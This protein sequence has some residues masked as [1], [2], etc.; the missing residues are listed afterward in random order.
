MINGEDAAFPTDKDIRLSPR[1]AGLSKREYFAV[2][3]L[4]G[5]AAAG[6]ES[7]SVREMAELAVE[8][9][10]DLIIALNGEG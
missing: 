5:V 3:A 4:Q 2:M 8:L 9:A 1:F 7:L 10:V 6:S